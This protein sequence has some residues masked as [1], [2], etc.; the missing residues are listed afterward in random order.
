MKRVFVSLLLVILLGA[1]PAVMAQEGEGEGGTP[2]QFMGKISAIED[3]MLQIAVFTVDPSAAVLG[4]V[5]EVGVQ[6]QV[7]GVLQDGIVAASDIYAVGS[8]PAQPVNFRGK[9]SAIE[10]GM[11]QVSVFTVNVGATTLAAEPEVG[12]EV[13]VVGG[14]V[15]GVVY[16]SS[17]DLLGLCTLT[18]S[19]SSANLRSAPGLGA[20]GVGY[21]YA[22]E[23]YLIKEM[24]ESGTWALVS[25]GDADAWIALS[26]GELSGNNC[27]SLPVSTVPFSG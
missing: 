5:P 4:L 10:D 15:D 19:V 16:A 7:A 14:L 3:G 9:I 1:L 26:V 6:V 12:M 21:A 22:G 8:E 2:V 25:A 18:V 11:L 24:H 17:A 20:V 27:D 13:Q 23:E